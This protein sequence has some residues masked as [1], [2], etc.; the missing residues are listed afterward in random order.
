M[1]TP[2][3]VLHGRADAVL[4]ARQRVLD[5]AYAAN[6]ERFVNGPPLATRLPR[7]VWINPP[8]DKTRSELQLH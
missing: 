3:F 5:D 4:A 2:D 8:E 1:L 7:A 6:P